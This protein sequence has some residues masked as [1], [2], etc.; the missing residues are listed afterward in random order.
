MVQRE[1]WT[2]SS[3]PTTVRSNYVVYRPTSRPFPDSS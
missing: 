3:S 1:S 2:G